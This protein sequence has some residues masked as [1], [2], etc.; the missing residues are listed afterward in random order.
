MEAGTIG[1]QAGNSKICGCYDGPPRIEKGLF[2]TTAQFSQGAKEYAKAQHII[3]VDGKRL[4]KLMIEHDLGVFQPENLP[5]EKESI[6]T[7]LPMVSKLLHL[8]Q[9]PDGSPGEPLPTSFSEECREL[10]PSSLIVLPSK[11][12]YNKRQTK[13]KRKKGLRHTITRRIPMSEPSRQNH[14]PH[15]H[16][17]FPPSLVSLARAALIDSLESLII[18]EP[19]YRDPLS[20]RGL[21]EF[22]HLWLIWQFSKAVRDTWSPPCARQS[23]GKPADRR[24]C[25]PLALPTERHRA[26]LRCGCWGWRSIPGLG[27]SCA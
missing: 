10:S 20:L 21:E 9:I 2:I 13:S 18:F 4:T 1:W 14:C 11:I 12:C 16:R 15:S 5:P 19:E 7:T 27:I 26:V 23:L 22:S 25:N 17:L 3:L 8:T 24:L 6:A